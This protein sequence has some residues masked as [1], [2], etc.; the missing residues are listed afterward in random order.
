MITLAS[1]AVFA[2]PSVAIT[3]TCG[4]DDPAAP[5]VRLDLVLAK[6]ACLERL[7]PD[8]TLVPQHD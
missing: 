1:I 2:Q 8:L 7:R 6:E 3:S 5:V 4:G